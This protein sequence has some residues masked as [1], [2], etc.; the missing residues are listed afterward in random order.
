MSSST[1]GDFDR[2]MASIG[3]LMLHWCL[4]EDALT[5]E[6][7]RLRIESEGDANFVRVRGPFGDRLREWRGLLSQKTRRQPHVA[8]AVAALANEMEQ[9]RHKRN[10]IANDLAGASAEPD[11]EPHIR[12]AQRE[13]SALNSEVIRISLAELIEGTEAI[14]R[15]RAK[16]RTGLNI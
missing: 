3:S 10:L 4:L 6:I 15:C 8:E 12:C 5:D 7:R 11:E 1:P 14:D 16:I 9:L 13:R 2:L